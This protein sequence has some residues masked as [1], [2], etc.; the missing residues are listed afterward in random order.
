[1]GF[2]FI[3][4]LG[5][6]AAW[7]IFAVYRWLRNG[8]FTKKWLRAYVVLILAG[9]MVGVWF[10]FFIQYKVGN[11]HLEGFPIPAGISTREAP[12]APWKT[13]ILPASIRIGADVTNL[14]GGVALS[15]API[16]VAAFFHENRGKGP[17]TNPNSP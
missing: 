15:L 10:A 13:A 9:L 1:M 17:F 8:E 12:D 3:I 2:I 11:T 5:A 6:L 16:A 4:P 14:L 7:S